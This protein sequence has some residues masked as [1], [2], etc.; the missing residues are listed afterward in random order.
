MKLDDYKYDDQKYDDYKY[1]EDYDYYN[2]KLGDYS[3]HENIPNPLTN[4]IDDD[5][6]P[7]VELHPNN[8]APALLPVPP[9]L[10]PS[11][12][13][14]DEVYDGRCETHE[15]II[16]RNKDGAHAH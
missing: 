14:Y 8:P 11:L 16:M 9:L 15:D 12:S 6:A 5:L 2:K 1:D 3:G 13:K 4:P 10:P 7:P